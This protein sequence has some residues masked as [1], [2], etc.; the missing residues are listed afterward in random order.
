M[1]SRV[2]TPL[3][4]GAGRPWTRVALALAF[5]SVV[6][7]PAWADTP[8][9]AT[10]KPE[11][12]VWLEGNSTLHRFE[13]HATKLDVRL[14]AAELPASLDANALEQFVKAGNVKSVDVE[15][16]I[17]LMKSEKSGLDK[18]MQ[19]AL[20]ADRFPKITCH[21]DHYSV[22]QAGSSDSLLL[23]ANGTLSIAGVEKPVELKA[24]ATRVGDALRIRGT[25]ELLMTTF[26]V[27]PPSMMMG[28]V[29]TSDQIVIQ[30]DL[31]LTPGQSNALVGTKGD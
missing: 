24:G 28:A 6:L 20:K 30:F 27:K 16:P 8:T 4:T 1:N 14:G 23:Q 13:S 31:W 17:A 19:N 2:E 12:R 26:G 18:N 21:L 7:A 11:S 29:K 10:A 9:I 15:I 22:S 5:A 3:R 25:K